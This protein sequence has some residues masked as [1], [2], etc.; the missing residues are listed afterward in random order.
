MF[1]WFYALHGGSTDIVS[2]CGNTMCL[3]RLSLSE[4]KDS[5]ENQYRA[6]RLSTIAKWECGSPWTTFSLHISHCHSDDSW[7]T[8]CRILA[9]PWTI[10]SL[11]DS[12]DTSCVVRFFS[13]PCTCTSHSDSR[14]KHMV[15]PQTETIS[16]SCF[17]E[18]I[19]HTE[20]C[21]CW[22]HFSNFCGSGL[23]A[24][25]KCAYS[26]SNQWHHSIVI[27][28]QFQWVSFGCP[29]CHTHAKVLQD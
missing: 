5:R 29:I 12:W 23:Y 6:T 11:S 13:E 2:V 17:L 19:T 16:G 28:Q 15:L 3:P 9:L 4:I 10:I 25:G 21:S 22:D 7:E 20:M 26:W 18:N 8:S 24:Y 27:S 1:I 14:D